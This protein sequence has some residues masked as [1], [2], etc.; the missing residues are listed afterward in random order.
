MLLPTGTVSGRPLRAI[1]L[2]QS[3]TRT[4][5]ALGF[6]ARIGDPAHLHDLDQVLPGGA[7]VGFTDEASSGDPAR[8][9]GGNMSWS[10]AY[11]PFGNPFTALVVL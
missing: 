8:D 10:Q 3:G 11:D 2:G 6:R 1:D 9:S 7:S 4:P 5:A